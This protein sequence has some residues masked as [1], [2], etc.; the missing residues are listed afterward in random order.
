MHSVLKSPALTSAQ[1]AAQLIELAA[2]D[3]DNVKNFIKTLADN[4]RLLL[5]PEVSQL[6]NQLKLRR[7][8]QVDVHIQSAYELTNQDQEKLGATLKRHFSSEV[9]IQTETD[10]DLIGGVVIH[11]NG[12]VIDASIKGRL[13]RFAESSNI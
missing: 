6:F 12:S 3:D 11:A 5:L 7:E 4:N 9:S 2:V 8:Q 1:K 10:S 13:N